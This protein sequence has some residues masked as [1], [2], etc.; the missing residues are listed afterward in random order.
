MLWGNLK[1][2]PRFKGYEFTEG[3]VGVKFELPRLLCK[4]EI[5][6]RFLWTR[7]DHLTPVSFPPFTLPSESCYHGAQTLLS[8][9]CV[10]QESV[11]SRLESSKG[12]SL[13]D[14]SEFE[15]LMVI[16]ADANT[17]FSECKKSTEDIL[18]DMQAHHALDSKGATINLYQYGVIGGIMHISL[19]QIPPQP[20]IA[21]EWTITQIIEEGLKE[22][23]YPDVMI[24]TL[25][26]TASSDS[27]K[28]LLSLG[29]SSIPVS[30]LMTLT[31][32]P[33]TGLV[34]TQPPLV[35][36]WEVADQ[37]WTTQ[38]ISRASYNATSS[39]VSF[40]LSIPC[41]VA[42]FQ[43]LYVGVP[44][45]HWELRPCA[46]R[47]GEADSIGESAAV[48]VCELATGITVHIGIALQTAKYQLLPGNDQW[49]E[50]AF[51]SVCG[52][53]LSLAQLKRALRYMGVNLFSEHHAQHFISIPQKDW[54]LE[55]Q[56][57]NQMA[58]LASVFAFSRSC[59]NMH[60]ASEKFILQVCEPI[61]VLPATSTLPTSA[62]WRL[63]AV[64]AR[65]AQW[66]NGG[67]LDPEMPTE[68]TPGQLFHGLLWNAVFTTA[69]PAGTNRLT[70]F[71]AGLA[72]A[73]RKI[74][75]ATRPLA[76]S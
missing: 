22:I 9:C 42:L 51:P 60:S 39:R 38:G 12:S 64:T 24:S 55:K 2:N 35:A 4:R 63:I 67:D 48:L 3:G 29:H 7:Y 34:I 28:S 14:L 5:A 21:G 66:I 10:R 49:A 31:F 72:H 46:M 43:H 57:Y 44:Y 75:H 40:R 61:K 23:P 45:A 33:P 65:S 27:Q 70:N 19:F 17:D 18:S 25:M 16:E 73:V 30:Q 52:H 1:K 53:W 37:V 76:F 26:L 69:S 20:H 47:N 68:P 36:R 15:G 50:L 54:Q 41:S 74:L 11:S 71:P 56:S 8:G 59:W 62:D 32:T 58:L 6:L 13:Q